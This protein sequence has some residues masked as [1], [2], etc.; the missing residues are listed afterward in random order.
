MNFASEEAQVTFDDSKTS[1][2]DIAKIIEKTGYGA[3]E[4]TEDALPQPEE[5]AHVSWRL[6]L[7]LVINIPFLIGMAGMMI[8]RH[9]WMIPPM[10][11]FV[12]ASIV[13][14]WLAIPF[15][16]A[17][18]RALKADWR[19]WTY[20]LPS[21]RYRFT[22]IPFICCFQPAHGARHGTRVF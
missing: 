9:D 20:L 14:L 7:L 4:K 13:Q 3:K 12:L 5:T 11:Q 2:A 10:W 19:I 15:T 1:A 8:G 6:W 17:R 16:K 18:G 21:A 22:C